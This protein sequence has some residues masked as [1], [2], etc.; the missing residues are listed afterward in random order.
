M[1]NVRIRHLILGFLDAMI[2]L[3]LK[4]KAMKKCVMAIIFVL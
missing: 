2:L 4:I 1:W 3:P